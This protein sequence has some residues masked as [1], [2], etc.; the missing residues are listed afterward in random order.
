MS[1]HDRAN[2]ITPEGEIPSEG[3]C[4]GYRRGVGLLGLRR[5]FRSSAFFCSNAD[6]FA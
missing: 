5:K 3:D 6:S 4:P 1:T 2:Q